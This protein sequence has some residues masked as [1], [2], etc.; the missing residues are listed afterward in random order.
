MR[1]K[2]TGKIAG[3]PAL[4]SNDDR[5]RRLANSIRI[6]SPSETLWSLGVIS[7]DMLRATSTVHSLKWQ[8]RQKNYMNIYT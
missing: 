7:N 2:R 5:R 3:G 4:A 6:I 8:R 1:G